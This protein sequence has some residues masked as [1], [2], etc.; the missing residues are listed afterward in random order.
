M[1]IKTTGIVINIAFKNF[2]ILSSFLD[3]TSIL[4]FS[5]ILSIKFIVLSPIKLN[6]LKNELRILP[7]VSNLIAKFSPNKP[8]T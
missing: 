3:F 5:F 7:I 4:R 6:G 8:K 2:F 1:I